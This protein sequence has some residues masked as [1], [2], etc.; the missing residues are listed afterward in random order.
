MTLKRKSR[1]PYP[2]F[3]IEDA[4]DLIKFIEYEYDKGSPLYFRGMRCDWGLVPRLEQVRENLMDIKDARTKDP[5]KLLARVLESEMVFLDNFKKQ[6]VEY[7]H[8]IPSDDW[9]WLS[10]ARHHGIP[11]RIMDWTTNALLALWFAVKNPAE[12][13]NTGVLWIFYPWESHD[14]TIEEEKKHPLE[15]EELKL[16]ESKILSSR[17]SSQSSVFTLHPIE[18]G[19]KGPRFV[20][21]QE[22]EDCQEC[23]YKFEI[24]RRHFFHI[25]EMLE[26]YC[27]IHPGSV[28]PGLDGLGE[29]ISRERIFPSDY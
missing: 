5:E 25:R 17:I 23:L 14:L 12:K 24:P 18:V 10:L 29:K 9:E 26:Q 1:R 28:F 27:G 16:F 22:K 2:V 6:A 19:K 11:T 20:P 4:S 15:I 21:L 8:H 3:E 7:L 13:N